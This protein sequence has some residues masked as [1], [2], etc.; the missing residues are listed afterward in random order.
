M[1]STRRLPE[2][3][4]LNV[5]L[6]MMV[7]YIHAASQTLSSLDR[8]SWQYAFVLLVQRT[9][10]I[11]VPAFIFLSGLRLTLP[12][13][14]RKR[15]LPQY[16]LDRSRRLLVPYL[17]AATVHYLTFIKLG[18]YTFSLKELLQQT[19]RGNLSAQFYFVIVLIQFTL[20]SPL[21]R[22]LPRRFEPILMLLPALVITQFSGSFFSSVAQL[23]PNTPL[24]H[25]TGVIFT[26]FLFYYLAGCCAGDRY[27]DFRALLAKNRPL[28]VGMALFFTSTDLLGCLL[29]YSGR[30]SISYLES[31]H[32][33]YYISGILFLCSL[34]PKSWGGA[35][36]WLIGRADRASYLIYLYHCLVITLFNLYAP[37]WGLTGAGRQFLLRILATYGVT[38][39]GC[40]LWQELWKNISKLCKEKHT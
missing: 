7:I 1:A 9:A 31:L 6:C 20:L 12:S 39:S 24:Q 38:I 10:C 34:P 33:L 8:L 28:I 2:L 36:G 18:W 32:Q 35:L 21:F 30:L 11:A 40:V 26:N 16:Y 29:H 17:L 37:A 25:Y 3:S 23:F 15:S 14:G 27:Q 22:A 5:L 19:A 4:N 13:P